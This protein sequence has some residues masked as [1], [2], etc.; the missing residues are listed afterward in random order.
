MSQAKNSGTAMRASGNMIL[1][2]LLNQKH[3]STTLSQLPGRCCAHSATTDDDM[4]IAGI[5]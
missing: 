2:E 4:V 3:T 1:G 5:T